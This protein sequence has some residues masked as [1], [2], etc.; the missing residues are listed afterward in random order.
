MKASPLKRGN[1]TRIKPEKIETYYMV[2]K[3]I[4]FVENKFKTSFW[5]KIAVKL[6]GHGYKIF[7]IVQNPLFK[8]SFG[9]VY[10]IPFPRKKDLKY[11][12]KFT[13]LS[14][15]DRNS[16]F[17]GNN[18]N[19]YSY[20]HQHIHD[21]IKTVNPLCV[22]G[23]TTLFH[24][25]LTSDICKELGIKYLHP[26]SCRYPVG[27]LSFYQY[28]SLVPFDEK[29]NVPAEKIDY[30]IAESIVNRNT[31]PDYM[32][33][34][35]SIFSNI[36]HKIRILRNWTASFLSWLIGE[37]YNTPSPYIKFMVSRKHKINK[38]I[39][40]KDLAVDSS[41]IT[42]WE[43]T[44]VLPLQMQPE[45]NIDVWGYPYNNQTENFKNIYANLPSG[46][47]M[48]IKPNPKSKYELSAS[49]IEF[50]QQH[51]NIFVLS[52][53][54]PME[55]IF[56]KA[57]YFYS[58]S[59]TITYEA[60]MAHKFAF[61]SALPFLK[62]FLPEALQ[63][64]QKIKIEKLDIEFM[65]KIDSGQIIAYQRANS[66]EGIVGDKIH[67]P[68]SQMPPNIDNVANAFLEVLSFLEKTHL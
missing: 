25:I 15:K 26:T 9:T 6:S 46:W 17:F 62:Y 29:I 10:K 2:T 63:P 20:Y 48:L 51:S 22:F 13:D 21:I 23:E 59:G 52:H 42:D 68:A 14:Q 12:D 55:N 27:R 60:I 54:E 16:Y 67:S 57:K 65:K 31:L 49:L 28:T 34:K 44:L 35:K 30:Q 53:F 19:H 50:I 64:P 18:S 61:A 47:K 11:S 37:K 38:R 39:W 3:N 41:Q 43:K 58:V 24:E 40:E 45:S 4:I 32:K 8:P 36:W 7:W 5:Q 66:F 1:S 56:D 33:K